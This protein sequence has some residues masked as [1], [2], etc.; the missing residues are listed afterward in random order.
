MPPKW[1]IIFS[2]LNS[3]LLPIYLTRFQLP[4]KDV[5]LKLFALF[6]I[7]FVD[8]YPYSCRFFTLFRAL[9]KNNGNIFE[10]ETA[11]TI[12]IVIVGRAITLGRAIKKK[13]KK[14]HQKLSK[15]FKAITLQGPI[16]KS[17]ILL[18]QSKSINKVP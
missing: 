6:C 17:P 1:E 11:T 14:W 3:I 5:A 2:T 13:A 9:A 7:G 10:C 4:T 12:A 8:W 16:E 18:L 15:R